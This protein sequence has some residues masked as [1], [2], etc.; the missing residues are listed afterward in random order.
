MNWIGILL[1]LFTF[2]MIGGGF[3]WVIKLEYYVGA[4][5]AKVVAAFGV[6]VIL[7]S[8]FMPDFVTSALVGVVGGSIV[9]GATELPDQQERVARGI[10]PANPNKKT[11]QAAPTAKGGDGR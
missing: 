10:F 11:R 3:V 5:I 1:G 9:W 7:L 6:L 8:L 4:Q 2:L